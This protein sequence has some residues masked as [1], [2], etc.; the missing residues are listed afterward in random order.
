MEDKVYSMDELAWVFRC[1]RMK[2]VQLCQ[3]GTIRSFRVRGCYYVYESAI[4]EYLI[5]RHRTQERKRAM[6]RAK[7]LIGRERN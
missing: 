2:A 4:A 6:E 5:R 1:S 3:A 7:R